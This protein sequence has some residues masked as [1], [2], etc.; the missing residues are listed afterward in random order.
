VT[1]LL[2]M[3]VKRLRESVLLGATATVATTVL[4]SPLWRVLS[5]QTV[6]TT[7]HCRV[8][9]LLLRRPSLARRELLVVLLMR[10][11]RQLSSP[12]R[13]GLVL[14]Q[15]LLLSITWKQGTSLTPTTNG[16]IEPR[17]IVH[18][19]QVWYEWLLVGGEGVSQRG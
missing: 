3:I 17:S 15:R 8:L 13:H 7:L 5:M 1:L 19:L 10:W 4:L 6:E 14:M 2:V 9:L 11:V 12:V 16:R 18:L